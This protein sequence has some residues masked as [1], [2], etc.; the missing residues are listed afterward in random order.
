MNVEVVVAM[1]AIRS[2]LMMVVVLMRTDGMPSIAASAHVLQPLKTIIRHSL[3]MEFKIED[4]HVL[5][6]RLVERFRGAIRTVRCNPAQIL[7]SGSSGTFA[8]RTSDRDLRSA[9]LSPRRGWRSPMTSFPRT[10]HTP[11]ALGTQTER[12]S[13]LVICIFTTSG[14]GTIRKYSRIARCACRWG[15]SGKKI[16]QCLR[17][18]DECRHNNAQVGGH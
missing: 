18:K 5:T 8:E 13:V 4:V 2:C 12:R 10:R 3:A 15:W 14:D 7:R 9:A 11:L 16:L 1:P 17:H 6:V